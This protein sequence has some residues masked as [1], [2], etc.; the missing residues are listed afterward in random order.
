MIRPATLDD[1]EAI[2]A[3]EAV[4]FGPDA[5]TLE[6]VVEEL[7]GIGRRGWVMVS[8]GRIAGYV[9]TREVGEV[10]DLQRIGVHPD[11]QR[12]GLAGRLL[13]AALAGTAADRMLLEVAEDNEAALAFYT[14][15]GFVEIDRRPRYY[16]SGAAAI[17]MMLRPGSRSGSAS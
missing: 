9:I 17:V 5:W 2:S 14:R 7:S 1:A 11:A 3:L 13:D 8:T 10:A 15:R 4:L 12:Q 6:Q 16:R